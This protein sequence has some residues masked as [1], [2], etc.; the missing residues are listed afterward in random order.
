MKWTTKNILLFVA[1]SAV[2]IYLG[3]KAYNYFYGEQE[4][5]ESKTD[6]DLET[7]LLPTGSSLKSYALSDIS[8]RDPF[9][10][11]VPSKSKYRKA[12]SGRNHT[13][14]PTNRHNISTRNLSK[15]NSKDHNKNTSIN[16]PLII[17]K[18]IIENPES[19]RTAGLLKIN[20]RE[21]FFLKG[22][23]FFGV[24]VNH[25]FADSVEVSFAKDFKTIVK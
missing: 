15:Q 22:E 10:D 21:M 2:W 9:L 19:G 3:F 4:I 17:Y 11:K 16:W 8:Y 1:V 20:D 12:T 23:T 14:T 18:G 25:I 6:L 13:S 24:T 7:D 5:L